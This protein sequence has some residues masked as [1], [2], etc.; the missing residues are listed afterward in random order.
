MVQP[1]IGSLTETVDAQEDVD[2]FVQLEIVMR[3]AVVAGRRRPADLA[4]VQAKPIDAVGIAAMHRFFDFAMAA[5]TPG[6]FT[7]AP[8]KTAYYNAP[9]NRGQRSM[10]FGRRNSECGMNRKEA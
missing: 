2:R 3:F 7:T 10:K 4:G 9:E 6:H 1:N 5:N 8:E